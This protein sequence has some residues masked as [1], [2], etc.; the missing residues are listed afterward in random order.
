MPVG[1]LKG[2]GPVI[3]EKLAN[4]GI[5]TVEELL[6]FVPVRWLDRGNIKKISELSGGR[7]CKPRGDG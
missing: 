4:K 2:V 5:E 1:S 3:A 6:Y 7:G